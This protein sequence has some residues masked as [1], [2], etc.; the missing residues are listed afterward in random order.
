MTG[1]DRF[2]PSEVSVH[3]LDGDAETRCAHYAGPDDRLA[4]RFRCCGRYYCCHACHDALTSH[5]TGRW[6]IDA[7]DRRAILCGACRSEL[8]I[9]EYLDHATHCPRCGAGFNPRC[10]AH[11]HL[12]FDVDGRGVSGSR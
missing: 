4:I 3:G 12:Y 2:E 1:R 10:A 8:T 7:F 9:R 6:P 11:H 5:E